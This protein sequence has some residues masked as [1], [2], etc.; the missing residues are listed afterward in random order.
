MKKAS[1]TV[2]T[3]LLTGFL[4]TPLPAQAPT[5][6]PLTA[7]TKLPPVQKFKGLDCDNHNILINK[8]GVITLLLGTS[9]DSQ[10]AARRAGK[11]MYPLQ[12]RPDFQLVVVVDL[13]DS[14]ATWAPSIVL[15]QM[16]A[17]LDKEAVDLKPYFLANGNKANPRDSSHVIAEFSNNLCP[18]LGWQEGSDELR[19]ILFG[20]DG[21][22]IKRWEKIEDMNALQT[23]VRA[24]IEELMAVNKAK[25]AAAAKSQGTKLIQPPRPAPPLPPPV[26]VPK[27]D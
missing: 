23:D 16:R 27:G 15:S 12:G 7:P 4:A 22:E 19:G 11:A 8:P 20:A 14:L 2:A 24:A 10:D 26:P 6:L 1:K 18:Q 3:L 9:E 13:R 21:R 5:P 25:A 17:N